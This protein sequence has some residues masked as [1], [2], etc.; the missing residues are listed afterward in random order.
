MNDSAKME[1]RAR[2]DSINEQVEAITQAIRKFE[3]DHNDS[4]LHF[5]TSLTFD[6]RSKILSWSKGSSKNPQW[7]LYVEEARGPECT[8]ATNIKRISKIAVLRVLPAMHKAILENMEALEKE[9]EK[10]PV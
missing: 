10:L 4:R 7:R 1:M 2:V 6:D 8:P 9:L 3:N 5:H